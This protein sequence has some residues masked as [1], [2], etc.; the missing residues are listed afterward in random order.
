MQIE[1]IVHIWQEG[2]QFIAQA[3]PLDVV[4]S[5]QTVAEAR[6]A[7]DEAMSLFLAT[8]NDMGTLAEILEEAGYVYEQGTWSSPVWVATERHSALVEA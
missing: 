2:S 1:Y 4:S 3:L 8:L 5:G 7:L 6:T